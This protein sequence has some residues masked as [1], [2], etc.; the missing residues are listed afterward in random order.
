MAVATLLLTVQRQQSGCSEIGLMLTAAGRQ[1]P[2]W[3]GIVR[4]FCIKDG[5]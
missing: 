4:E 3:V 2:E 5:N 1:L